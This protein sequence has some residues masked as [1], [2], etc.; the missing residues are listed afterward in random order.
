[1][2]KCASQFG[3]K[4]GDTVPLIGGIFRHPDGNDAAWEFVVEGIYEPRSSAI[5]N[6][7]MFFNWAYFQ[8]TLESGPNSFTPGVGTVVLRL[9]DGAS[10]MAVADQIESMYENGP[11]RVQ[12]TTEAEFQAQFVSMVGSVPRL[13]RTEPS[14]SITI[15]GFGC[16]SA[17]PR[18]IEEASPIV[19]SM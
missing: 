4:V 18:P 8:E 16:A 19:P 13:V 14:P 10:H 12:V 6:R 7:T 11:Q 9:S 15:T 3:W 5:D 2:T 1:M 17:R